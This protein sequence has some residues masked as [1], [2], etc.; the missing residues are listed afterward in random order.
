MGTTG[1]TGTTGS[2]GAIGSICNTRVSHHPSIPI[3][4]HTTPVNPVV[5]VE[6]QHCAF[7]RA[8][9]QRKSPENR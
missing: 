4:P 6:R 1:S 3:N 8:G 9:K 5:R 2:I 7:S